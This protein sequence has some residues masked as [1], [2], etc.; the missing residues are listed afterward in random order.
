MG[1][2]EK[3]PPLSALPAKAVTQEAQRA[4]KLR[5]R[6]FSCN[7][8]VAPILAYT[9]LAI[10]APLLHPTV[11]QFTVSGFAAGLYHMVKFFDARAVGTR[12]MTDARTKETNSAFITMAALLPFAQMASRKKDKIRANLLNIKPQFSD[13]LSL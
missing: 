6:E 13:E 1:I 4:G 8:H 9:T 10:S 12:P 11:D 5:R 7:L 3:Q 2:A